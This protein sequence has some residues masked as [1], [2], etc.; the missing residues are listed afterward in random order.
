MNGW[1]LTTEEPTLEPRQ[2]THG[3]CDSPG[4]ETETCHYFKSLVST[5]AP[6]QPY[7]VLRKR[8]GGHYTR[9]ACMGETGSK[10]STQHNKLT[11]CA[12][13]ETADRMRSCSA[14]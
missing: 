2:R 1:V 14:R 12:S 8:V 4:E 13:E 9:V 7:S 10:P 11:T 5:S 3:P 6:A